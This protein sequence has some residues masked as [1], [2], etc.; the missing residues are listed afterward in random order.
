MKKDFFDKITKDYDARNHK[1]SEDK[2]SDSHTIQFKTIL[3]QIHILLCD[4][5]THQTS[6]TNSEDTSLFKEFE[7]AIQVASHTIEKL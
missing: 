7:K 4:Y 2:E 6:S 3:K 1:T 5:L